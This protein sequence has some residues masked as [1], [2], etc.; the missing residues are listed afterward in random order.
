[1]SGEDGLHFPKWSTSFSFYIILL[2]NLIPGGIIL[3]TKKICY[4]NAIP[5]GIFWIF[6]FLNCDL[7]DE[8]DYFYIFYGFEFKSSIISSPNFEIFF[9]PKPLIIENSSNVCGL[10]FAI[11][12]SSVLWQTINPGTL[13]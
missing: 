8:D 3:G 11:V 12:I 4:N 2:Q 5:C 10:T 9:R 1:M 6:W 7:Y 13:S